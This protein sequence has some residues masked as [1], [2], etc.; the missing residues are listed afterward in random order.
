MGPPVKVDVGG[1][2][3]FLCCEGCRQA[4]VDSPQKYLSKLTAGDRKAAARDAGTEIDLPPIGLPEIVESDGG[5]LGEQAEGPRNEE[6]AKIAAALAALPPDDRLLARQQRVCPV[7]DSPLGLM[8][9]PI[10]MDVNGRAVFICCESCRE[11]LL[12]EPQKYLAKLPK[13]AIQ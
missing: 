3:V 4:M 12:A 8:G 1:V 7:A 10:K 2:T 9:T 11:R 13:E 5:T 6:A